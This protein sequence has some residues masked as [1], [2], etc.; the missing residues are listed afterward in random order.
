MKSTQFSDRLLTWFDQHG[1][2][3]LP[4][5]I[6]PT[7]YRVWVSE[8]MLQQTQVVTVIA[9]YLRFMAAFPS[10]AD[11]AG[12][13][14]D[15]V[16]GFW[17][18]LGYYARAR[19]LHKAAQLIMTEHKGEFPL[20]FESVV[21]LPGVG[22]S[23]AGAILAF[24]TEQRYAILDG[25]V[26]RILCRHE[27][28]E[29]APN[30]PQSHDKLWAIADSYTPHNRVSA[31]TQAIMDLGATLCTRI[32]PHCL[33]CPLQKTCK[34]RKLDRIAEF[35]IKV[36]KSPKPIQERL[37]LILQSP[38]G[39]LLYQRPSSGIWGGLW[40][41]PEWPNLKMNSKKIKQYCQ[42]LL[43]GLQAKKTLSLIALPPMQHHFTHY[44][45]VLKPFLFLTNSPVKGP[46]TFEDHRAMWCTSA[47]LNTLGLPA[48]IKRLLSQ[49]F[50]T[51]ALLCPE[52][53]IA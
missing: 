22:R 26:K 27:A 33:D 51:G 53:C 38:Q 11:L 35:P 25:N 36:Q 10:L 28:F 7:P 16:L 21:A 32:K 18:G 47:H 52:P 31:Y 45:L 19:H 6:E 2:K 30:T 24:S 34:A 9:Y 5:Q 41:L 42:S 1:R 3:H 43:K 48:P 50:T 40:S 37:F 49:Q 23:T 4:W 29:M 14:V 8:I 46:V 13:S 12:A 15:D 17:S 39:I 20:D 44:Q